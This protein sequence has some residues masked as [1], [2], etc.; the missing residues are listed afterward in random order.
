MSKV[1]NNQALSSYTASFGKYG[2]YYWVISVKDPSVNGG[3][4]V[5]GP[6]MSFDVIDRCQGAK[7]LPGFTP[8]DVDLNQDCQVNMLD[9][10]IL[11]S[12][13]IGN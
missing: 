9:F 10:A 6:V 5:Y 11:A 13:W 3:N 12:V 4:P 2:E 1:V 8:L 7:R